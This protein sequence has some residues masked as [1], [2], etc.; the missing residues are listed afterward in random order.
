MNKINIPRLFLVLFLAGVVA[1]CRDNPDSKKIAEEKNE[2]TL[3]TRSAERDAQFVVNEVSAG[4]AIVDWTSP[5]VKVNEHRELRDIA[6]R[7][8]REHVRL[9]DKWKAYAEKKNILLPD[10]SV[11]DV[12]EKVKDFSEQNDDSVRYKF[13]VDEMLDQEKRIL[14]RLE[15]YM[16]DAGDPA[17]KLLLQDE[18]PVIRMNR[19]QLMMLKSKL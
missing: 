18:L 14:T 4:Y 19:D 5:V 1:S 3:D 15:D 2:K 7:L 11:G 17:L 9:I 6:F 10:S 16:D 8:Q 13:W 12:K